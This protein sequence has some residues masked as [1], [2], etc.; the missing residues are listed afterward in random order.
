MFLGAAEYVLEEGPSNDWFSDPSIVLWAWLSGAGALLFFWR[1]ATAQTPIV[2]LRPFKSATFSIGA[3]LG[4]ILGVGMFTSI[5]LTP[6]FLGSVRGYNSLQ[7][8]HTMFLQGFTMFFSAPIFGRLG[9]MMPDT[10]PLG[11]IGFL[12]LAVS[13]WLQAHLNTQSGLAELVLP[14]IFRGLGFM[15]TFTSVMQPALQSLDPSLLH[16]GAGLFNT[17]RNVGGAFGIAFL[18]TL[19][20]HAFALHRQELYSA[21]DPNNPHVQGMMAGMQAYLAEHNAVDPARQ[22]LLFYSQTLD[23]EA[24]AMTF[25]DQFLFL[26][27][28]VLL[29]TIPM[30]L[31]KR[32]PQRMMVSPPPPEEALAH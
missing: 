1:A 15:M 32:A 13:C 17:I 18:S 26:A 20:A 28:V 6:L 16:A 8:G 27:V 12:L 4:F 9:R 5:F 14:Q 7:I 19:Q 25:N 3:G 2:D 24:L 22:A 31:L 23:R 30:L 29:S 21:L 11:V 10:R